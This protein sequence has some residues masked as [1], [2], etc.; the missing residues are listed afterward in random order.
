VS[1]C[2]ARRTSKLLTGTEYRL[3]TSTVVRS[4]IS[5]LMY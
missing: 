1:I 4:T 5:R 3:P 2:A